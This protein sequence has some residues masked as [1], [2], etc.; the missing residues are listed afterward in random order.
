MNLHGVYP[1]EKDYWRALRAAQA[2]GAPEYR[3]DEFGAERRSY[4]AERIPRDSRYHPEFVWW[5]ASYNDKELAVRNT[6]VR[7]TGVRSTGVQQSIARTEDTL[8]TP[9][10]A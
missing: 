10:D 7:N 8:L 2:L 9:V 6:G 3:P 1:E 5:V 4:V